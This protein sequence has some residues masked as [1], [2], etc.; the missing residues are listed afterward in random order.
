LKHE[1]KTFVEP[2]IIDLDRL[3]EVIIAG[4][5][6]FSRGDADRAISPRAARASS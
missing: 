6:R 1:R 4:F 5:Y 3:H 2:R